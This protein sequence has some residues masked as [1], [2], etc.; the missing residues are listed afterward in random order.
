MI[1]SLLVSIN[2]LFHSLPPSPYLNQ[3][4]PRTPPSHR[5]LSP[6]MVHYRNNA[7]FAKAAVAIREVE[8]SHW[9]NVAFEEFMEVQH[10]GA[11]LK[12]GFSRLDYQ[13]K[14]CPAAFQGLVALLPH[15]ARNIYYRDQIGNISNSEVADACQ[16]KDKGGLMLVLLGSVSIPLSP[17][18]QSFSITLTSPH[19]YLHRC[20][21]ARTAWSWT[22]SCASRSS[23]AGRRSSTRV[24]RCPCRSSSPSARYG[25]RSTCRIALHDSRDGLPH[26]SFRRAP[27]QAPPSS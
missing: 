20:V 19:P 10:A 7:P 16:T 8:V 4:P 27:R 5:S 24:T 15:G 6:L 2:A 23:A 26:R 22:W 1:C 18:R 14:D 13:A 17:V 9:G 3:N 12:G 11:K 21:T 25:N